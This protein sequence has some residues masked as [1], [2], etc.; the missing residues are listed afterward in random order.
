[1]Q[2]MQKTT[3][4]QSQHQIGTPGYSQGMT[5][6]SSRANFRNEDTF[7]TENGEEDRSRAETVSHYDD[8]NAKSGGRTSKSVKFAMDRSVKFKEDDM[9]ER[10]E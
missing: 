7:I 9:E 6:I 2:E 10:V 4:S 5:G 1:M 8:E 3:R